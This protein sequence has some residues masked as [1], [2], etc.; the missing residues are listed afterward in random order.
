MIDPVRDILLIIALGFL[1]IA[2]I[3][4]LVIWLKPTISHKYCQECTQ[5]EKGSKFCL[6]C[7][8]PRDVKY[9]SKYQKGTRDVWFEET[10]YVST[11]IYDGDDMLAGIK[12]IGP[13]VIEQRTTT[14]V[15]PPEYS[16]EVSEYGDFIMNV[17][18]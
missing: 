15:V 1:T 5:S 16:V 10:G 14:I 12:V 17:P 11:P 13:C 18:V 6:S 4:K 3:M 8:W 9:P 2:L 7:E